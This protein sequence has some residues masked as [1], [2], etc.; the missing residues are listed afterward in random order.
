MSYQEKFI[1][2]KKIVKRIIIIDVV[3]CLF[4]F[5]LGWI[6]DL[7]YI[8]IWSYIYLFGVIIPYIFGV[9]ISIIHIFLTIRLGDGKKYQR[10]IRKLLVLECIITP[11]LF[12]FVILFIGYLVGAWGGL[13]TLGIAIPYFNIFIN[14]VIHAIIIYN[15]NDRKNKS[16]N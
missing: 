3:V 9:S 7:F 8:G 11:I 13:F 4:C 15:I 2:Y 16:I 14:T 12:L 6:L 5:I 1:K 10:I